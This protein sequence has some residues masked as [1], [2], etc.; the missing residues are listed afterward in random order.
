MGT[1][2]QHYHPS[3]SFEAY[4]FEEHL[5]WSYRLTHAKQESQAICQISFFATHS[6]RYSFQEHLGWY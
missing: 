6:Q 1:H 5:G 3:A 4:S 2:P